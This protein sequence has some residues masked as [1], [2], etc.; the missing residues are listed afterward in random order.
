MTMTTRGH[1]PPSARPARLPA[2][3]VG[4]APE[5]VPTAG[6]V[7]LLGLGVL[8]MVFELASGPERR[9]MLAFLTDRYGEGQS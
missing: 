6:Q 5:P 7:E 8:S 1:L 9:R 3:P 2:V 4:P